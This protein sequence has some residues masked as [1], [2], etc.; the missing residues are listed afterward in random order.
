MIKTSRQLHSVLGTVF[1]LPLVLSAITGA[2]YTLFDEI[3]K[4][5]ALGKWFLKL[6]TLELIGLEK[7]YPFILCACT[8]GLVGTGLYLA[9]RYSLQRR[10]AR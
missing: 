4:Q 6:H 1:S 2:S 7:V 3:L 5:K 10:K 8:L 9:I